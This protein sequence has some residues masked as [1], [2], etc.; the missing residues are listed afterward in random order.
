MVNKINNDHVIVNHV[1]RLIKNLDDR[2]TT[3]Q[4]K[5]LSEIS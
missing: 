5:S 2:K 4:D 3:G 1:N